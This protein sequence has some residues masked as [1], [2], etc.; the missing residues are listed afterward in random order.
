MKTTEQQI[1]DYGWEVECAT[2][3]VGA[4]PGPKHYRAEQGGFLTLWR[5]DIKDVLADVQKIVDCR[6]EADKQGIPF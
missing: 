2:G 3:W 4:A 5:P 1:Q 6:K